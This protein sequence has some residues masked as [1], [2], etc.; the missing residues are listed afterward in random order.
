MNPDVFK[1]HTKRP[2][3]RPGI[4]SATLTANGV[5][6]VG[7]SEA[8]DLCAISESGVWLPYHKLDG[9]PLREESREF[10][11]LRLT[12]E[13]DGKKYHSRSGSRSHLYQPVRLIDLLADPAFSQL[14]VC[15]GEFKALSACEAGIP[16]A[17]VS[18][19]GNAAPAGRL[20]DE[21]QLLL[22]DW[23]IGRLVF[24]G[25][26]DVGINP[27]FSR[28]MVKLAQTLPSGTD[29]AVI[30]PGLAAPAKGLD[31]QREKLGEGFAAY[32]E[33]LVSKEIAV[34]R[35]MTWEELALVLL[36]RED[37]AQIATIIKGD[38]RE[39]A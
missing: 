21:L 18:G 2:L 24:V 30:V 37:P 38:E 23:E 25:D 4:S 6:R 16:A 8:Q 19:I 15:E 10:G 13:I 7:P 22:G 39:A 5:R 14:Y 34:S 31:D 26:S 32:W 36:R 1:Q 17:G 12:S 33:E 20:V 28:A 35:D 27:D 29:L 3:T 9:T 11:R